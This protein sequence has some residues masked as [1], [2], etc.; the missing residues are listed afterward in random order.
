MSKKEEEEKKDI[1]LPCQSASRIEKKEREKITV[2]PVCAA[3]GRRQSVWEIRASWRDFKYDERER[4]DGT[5]RGYS[6][7]WTEIGI[8]SIRTWWHKVFLSY[9]SSAGMESVWLVEL[10]TFSAVSVC[11]QGK[12]HTFFLFSVQE[13]FSILGDAL[14]RFFHIILISASLH[15]LLVRPRT[16]EVPLLWLGHSCNAYFQFAFRSPAN[17]LYCWGGCNYRRCFVLDG[18]LWSH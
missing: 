15:W 10:C 17:S 18:W 2:T 9:A 5:G 11:F 4:R 14:C 12:P 6:N 3:W 7:N 8:I 1:P 13:Q 16:D